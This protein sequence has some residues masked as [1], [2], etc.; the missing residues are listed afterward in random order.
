V[1]GPMTDPVTSDIDRRAVLELDHVAKH[2]PGNPPVRALD[3]VSLTIMAGELTALIGPSGSGKSTLMNVIGTLD[4]PTAGEVRIDGIATTS[5]SDAALAGLRAARVGFVFQQF[6]L[7]EGAD[8][9]D[10]VASGLLYRGVRRGERRKRAAAALE[11][12]GLGHRLTY[13]PPQL[14]GGE[15]QRVA[16][17]RAIVGEPAI[18]LADEPTGNLDSTTSTSIIDLMRRLNDDGAT[19]IVI[20]H[21]TELAN[22][23]RRQVAM[24]DGLIISDSQPPVAHESNDWVAV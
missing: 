6:H 7:L 22:S 10:N 2:F 9:V 11:R 13:R 21:D 5:L 4:R 14:S 18:V 17:A 23:F 19:I 3:T 1:T 8:I 24:R 20:T 15:R 12:V 16:I